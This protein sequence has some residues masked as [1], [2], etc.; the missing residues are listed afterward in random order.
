MVTLAGQ[1]I[2]GGLLSSIVMTW[3]QVLV[4]PQS[5][6]DNQVLVIVYS[7]MQVEDDDVTSV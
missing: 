4:L 6:V 3:L 1:V 7:W 5:S 2:N